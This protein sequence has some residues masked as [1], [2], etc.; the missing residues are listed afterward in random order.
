M[1]VVKR[2]RFTVEM[3]RE[4]GWG[5]IPHIRLISHL[6]VVS[7]QSK[8][9]EVADNKQQLISARAAVCS[10]ESMPETHMTTSAN[11]DR[12]VPGTVPWLQ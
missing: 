1:K 5:D 9:G 4:R 12:L 6:I 2:L 3:L 11:I 7:W 10:Y 8:S